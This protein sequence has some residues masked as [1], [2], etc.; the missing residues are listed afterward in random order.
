MG[1]FVVVFLSPLWKMVGRGR[2]WR[3]GKL[4]T[5]IVAGIYWPKILAKDLIEYFLTVPC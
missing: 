5:V 2:S 4:L 1:M 3:V